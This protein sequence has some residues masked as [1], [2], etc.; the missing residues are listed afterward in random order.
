MRHPKT[1]RVLPV[2]T[3]TIRSANIGNIFKKPPIRAELAGEWLMPTEGR[4]MR[5]Y[6]GRE[7]DGSWRGQVEDIGH[8]NDPGISAFA[9]IRVLDDEE[10]SLRDVNEMVGEMVENYALAVER[11]HQDFE[12]EEYARLLKMRLEALRDNIREMRRNFEAGMKLFFGPNWR[13][14]AK[15]LFP[16]G[17]PKI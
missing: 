15:Q 6:Y 7:P 5:A 17:R 4:V 13:V 9:S 12:E 3:D 16:E 2:G 14:A 8:V 10:V 1:G 11:D